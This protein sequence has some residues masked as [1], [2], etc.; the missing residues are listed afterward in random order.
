MNNVEN[1][2][3]SD[4]LQL[5][6]HGS[7]NI[8]SANQSLS[9][10]FTVAFP[11]CHSFP[12]PSFS[13]LEIYK[14]LGDCNDVLPLYKQSYVYKLLKSCSV[15]NSR[16]DCSLLF[17]SLPSVRCFPNLHLVEA[18]MMTAPVTFETCRRFQG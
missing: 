18:S 3:V 2:A 1:L 6:S 13:T 4:D 17:L 14:G 12:L 9:L 15:L 16:M 10:D 11:C 5:P 8:R 7:L